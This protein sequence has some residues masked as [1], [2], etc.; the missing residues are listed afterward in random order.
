MTLLTSRF[1][2]EK[3]HQRFTSKKAEA[4]PLLAGCMG[5]APPSGGRTPTRCVEEIDP[6]TNSKVSSRH[7]GKTEACRITRV[8]EADMNFFSTGE[9]ARLL[10]VPVHRIEYAH[11]S[12]GLAEPTLRFL[13]KR[14]YDAD[15]VRRAA[16]HFG[17]KL[18][19]TSFPNG[20]EVEQTCNSNTRT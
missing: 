13:G 19:P 3:A 17:I 7:D 4:P 16:L 10:A 20:Q 11:R 9:L 15:D 5:S 8:K 2:V 18:D 12:Q 1:G 6:S 14:V